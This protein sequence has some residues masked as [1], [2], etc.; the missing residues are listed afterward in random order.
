VLNSNCSHVGGCGLGSPQEQWLRADL[1][2]HPKRCTLAYWH[3]PAFSSG[4][5]HGGSAAVVALFGALRDHR[6]D[7]LLSGHDHDYERFARQ[8]A[9][10]AADAAGV[11]QFVVGTG[12]ADL[13]RF[14]AAPQP[15]SEVRIAEAL[16]VLHLRLEA[17]SYE[18]RF[19]AEPGNPGRDSGRA[20]C[21]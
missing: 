12:G 3:H 5:E 16:G 7:V 20:G 21:V 6:A 15:N 19:V 13:R 14:A 10:G 18:W 8:S 2:A 4:S 9:G 17:S 1:A 11:R